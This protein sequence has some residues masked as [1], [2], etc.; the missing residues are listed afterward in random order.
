MSETKTEIKEKNLIQ[1]GSVYRLIMALVLIIAVSLGVVAYYGYKKQTSVPAPITIL[2]EAISL[3]N[4]N[5]VE[6]LVKNGANIEAPINQG[7]DGKYFTALGWALFSNRP[8]IAVYLIEHRADVTAP[9]PVESSM[10]YW[11]LAH[12]MREVALLLIDK[13]AVLVAADGYNPAQH[14]EILGFGEVV[15]A[16]RE[17]GIEPVPAQSED[18]D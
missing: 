12:H 8:E 4:L 17:K 14:A 1:R 13:G 6:F 9:V 10:L 2:Q 16:L 15:A 7:S 5:A 3:N 11:A 18:L